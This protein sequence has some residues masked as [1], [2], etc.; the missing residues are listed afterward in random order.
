MPPGITKQ[1]SIQNRAHGPSGRILADVAHH[2]EVQRS[3]QSPG[4]VQVNANA[5]WR[6]MVLRFR[7]N[8]PEIILDQN[9]DQGGSHD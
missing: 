1:I 6:R 8:Q 3:Q 2:Q 9:E 4:E 7:K 5:E